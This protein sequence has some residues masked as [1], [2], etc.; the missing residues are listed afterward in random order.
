MEGNTQAAIAD[1]KKF[2]FMFHAGCRDLGVS[3]FTN[4]TTAIFFKIEVSSGWLTMTLLSHTPSAMQRRKKSGSN[5]R[6][7]T[8]DE[9]QESGIA[10]TADRYSRNLI[11]SVAIMNFSGPT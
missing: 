9:K 3:N 10:T 7:L 1:G 2:V 11:L 4:Y 8:P 5:I 6:W